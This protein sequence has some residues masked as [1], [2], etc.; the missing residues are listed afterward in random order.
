MRREFDS[1]FKVKVAAEASKELE[2]RSEL[3]L[4]F[5]VRL[6]QISQWKSEFLE[7]S[8]AAFGQS[9][10]KEVSGD[11]DRESLYSKGG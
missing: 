1:S 5:D 8:S 4:R 9:G 2:T 6:N 7:N 10:R 3:A 11:L